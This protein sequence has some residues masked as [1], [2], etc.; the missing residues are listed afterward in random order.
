MGGGGLSG[1]GELSFVKLVLSA[2][3]IERVVLTEFI[4]FVV[5]RMHHIYVYRL[6]MAEQFLRI[7]VFF[8]QE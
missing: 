3:E 4:T 1:V 8:V 2:G 7:R 6:F 5:F